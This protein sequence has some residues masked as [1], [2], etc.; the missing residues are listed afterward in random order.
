MKYSVLIA[1]V[2]AASS[3]FQA[4]AHNGEVHNV[5][6]ASS[7]APIGVMGD[8]L[9]KKGEVMF[10]YRFMHMDMQGSRVGTRRQSAR[11]TVGSM[12][13]PGQFMVAPTEMPMDMHMLGAMIGLTDKVTVMAML[14]FLSNSMDHLIRNGKTFTTESSGMGDIKVSAMIKLFD[15]GSHKAHWSMGLSLPTGSIRERAD[16]PAQSNAVLPY[17]MQL[18]SGTVDYMPSITYTGGAA[19][20]S[21]GAQAS[22]VI[23]SGESAEQYSLGDRRAVTSW[24]ARDL[25]NNLSVSARL[26]YQD[27]DA[28]DGANQALNPRMIQTAD[29]QLQSGSRSDLSLGINYLFD[30]GHRLAFEYGEA[31]SQDLDGPQLETDSVWTLAWQK[32]F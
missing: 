30:G 27:W 1:A 21:W 10:S 11:E 31:V 32:A 9:H 22:A 19:S 23:R 6:T 13:S 16:T 24:I 3:S 29:P 26:N 15:T 14:P 4:L 7:H 25:S 2:L 12:M 28:I 8:H 17:P 18:G 20:W 5:S